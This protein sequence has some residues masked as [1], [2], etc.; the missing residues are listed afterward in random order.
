[1]SEVFV[2]AIIHAL[3]R[4]VVSFQYSKFFF[5]LLCVMQ[6]YCRTK[7]KALKI[8]HGQEALMKTIVYSETTRRT[9][10]ADPSESFREKHK[11]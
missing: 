11:N 5:S 8:P 2:C 9:Q 4:S 3:D 1:M 7:K 10:S 6:I